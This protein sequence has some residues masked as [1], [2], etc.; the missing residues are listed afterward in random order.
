[1]PLTQCPALLPTRLQAGWETRPQE[2]LSQ[3]NTA[4]TAATLSVQ[5]W[6]ALVCSTTVIDK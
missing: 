5:L 6:S 2:T 4:Q 1:M 3:T